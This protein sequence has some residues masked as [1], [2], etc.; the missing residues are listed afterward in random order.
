MASPD[1]GIYISSEWMSRSIVGGG[2]AVGKD[3]LTSSKTQLL[4]FKFAIT[5]ARQ[6]T[7][8]SNT[9]LP[10]KPRRWLRNL[11]AKRLLQHKL[12]PYLRVFASGSRFMSDSSILI[13]G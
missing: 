3:G 9:M 1:S 6:Q 10:A 8:S 13:V 2:I 4:N 5:A 7:S 11:S 12:H